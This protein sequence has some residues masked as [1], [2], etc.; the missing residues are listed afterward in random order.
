LALANSGELILNG[1]AGG[2]GGN[3]GNASLAAGSLNLSAGST[4]SVLGGAA[5]SSGT[6]GDASVQAGILTGS[7]YLTMGGVNENLQLSGGSFGGVAAGGETLV[8]TGSG[9]LTLTGVNTYTGG[10]Q[11]QSGSLVAGNLAALGAGNVQVQGGTLALAAP[12][13]IGGN[14]TQSPGGTLQTGLGTQLSIA[15]TAALAGTLDLEAPGGTPLH[16]HVTKTYTLLGA[17][18]VAGTFGTLT[19]NAV[20][21]PVSLVY[22]PASVSLDVFGPSFASVGLTGN[23]QKVGAGLDG[24]ASGPAGQALINYLDTLSDP[25]LRKGYDLLSPSGLT[26]L[27]RMGFGTAELES[28]LILQRLGNLFGEFAST[29]VAWNGEGPRFAGNLPASEEAA[30]S[31]GLTP[32]P[33]GVFA[34]GLGDFAAVTGDGNAP[35]YQYSTGGMLAGM[36]YRFSGE[37]AA[38]LMMGYSAS[39]TSQSNATVQSTG[40]QLGLYAGYTRDSLHLNGLLSGGINSYTTQRTALQGTA[41]GNTQGQALSAA[42]NVGYE[43]KTDGMKIQPFVTGQYSNVSLN[44]FSETGSLAPLSYAPQS[45]ASLQTDLGFSASR[46]WNLGGFSLAPSI[47]AAWEH[48]YQGNLD[49]LSASFGNGGGFS[50]NGPATGSDGAVLGAGLN[51]QFTSGFNLFASYQGKLG[52]TNLTQQN[53][54]GGLGFGF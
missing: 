54:S 13:S 42:L 11:I 15:G 47:N 23:Q 52:M 29:D 51:A 8:K 16:I 27:Y 41:S 39:G 30:M 49:S 26:S 17:S 32:D 14:Y 48:L 43:F 1:G 44:A 25:D 33:W 5:G 10:T 34:A 45:E 6:G 53:L 40:G 28:G 19:N 35:G 36:D 3:G 20:I 18:S 12:L 21:A 22:G 37:F 31:K 4:V 2:S 9:S 38:G 46:S 24:L 50:V 7:G